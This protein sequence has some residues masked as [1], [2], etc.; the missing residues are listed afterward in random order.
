MGGT[1][2]FGSAP[3]YKTWTVAFLLMINDL[4][5]VAANKWKYVDDTNV[6]EIVKR[7]GGL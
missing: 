7:G 5:C 4:K 3:R 2:T 6:A 1:C